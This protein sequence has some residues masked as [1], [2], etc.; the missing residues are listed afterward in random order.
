MKKFIKFISIIVIILIIVF[1]SLYFILTSSF[2]I[3]NVFFPITGSIIGAK[4]K[5]EKIVFSPF[6]GDCEIKKLDVIDKKNSY[7]LKIGNYNS[8]IDLFS[9][10]SG[11][12]KVNYFKLHDFDMSF[13]QTVYPDEIA[14]EEPNN[15]NY[16]NSND[17]G[18]KSLIDLDINNVEIKNFNIHYTVKRSTQK[19]SSLLELT[20]LNL[21]FPILKA[22][23]NSDMTFNGT[24]KTGPT[25]GKDKMTGKIQG[26]IHTELT[27]DSLPSLI[28]IESKAKFND[29]ETPIKIVFKAT[30]NI[31]ENIYPFQLNMNITNLPLLPFFKAFIEGSFSESKGKVDSFTLKSEGRNLL[32]PDIY[33]NIKGNL[34]IKITDLALPIE[35]AK[36]GPLRIIFLPIEILAHINNYTKSDTIPPGLQEVF[37]YTNN[38][39]QGLNDMYFREGHIDISLNKGVVDIKTL[40]MK[41]GLLRA[42]RSI[43]I[44]GRVDLNNTMDIKTTTNVLELIIP[45]RIKGTVD[46]PSPN[47]TMLLP[48]MVFGTTKNIVKSG[49]DIGTSITETGI[50]TGK[51]IGSFIINGGE[52]KQQ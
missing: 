8:N 18:I 24:I 16:I 52:K 50:N 23:K 36:Y 40:H 47:L 4:I 28:E 6:A 32:N 9:L 13:T 51:D 21:N 49:I 38:L 5:V 14:L 3:K 39:T 33:S 42:V 27:Y 43:L 34:Q 45:I 10:L 7:S 22:G 17:I 48:G 11:T 1:F 29:E 35:L 44:E 19:D 15:E 41:G 46:N 20:D 37:S 30:E 31:T 26:K 12:L 25:T 2:L